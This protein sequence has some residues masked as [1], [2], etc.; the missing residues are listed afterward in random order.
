[1]CKFFLPPHG[2]SSGRIGQVAVTLYL[3]EECH[4]EGGARIS[5]CNVGE[6]H[7][8]VTTKQTQFIDRQLLSLLVFSVVGD[9]L[10]TQLAIVQNIVVKN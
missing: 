4:Q 6:G 9:N 10:S 3:G 7:H 5:E 2:I 1:M 8:L